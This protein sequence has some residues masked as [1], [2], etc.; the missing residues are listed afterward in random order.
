MSHDIG[1]PR[2][3]GSRVLPPD[4]PAS[5]SAG[6]PTTGAPAGPETG[7]PRF[8]LGTASALV[9][10]S[11][12]G[13]GVFALP[14]AL[15]V[16]GPISLVAFVLVTIGAIALAL[17]FR[18]LAVRLPGA[19]GPYVYARDAFGEFAGF[20][21]AWSYWI[22]AWA[23]NAAIVVAWVG[24]VEVFWNTGHE[25]GWSIVIALT[26]LLLPALVNLLGLRSFAAFQ[27]VTT[28]LKFIPLVFMATIGLLFINT[29][30]FGDFNASGTSW[31]GAISAAGAIALFSY[32][33]IETASVAA[34]RVRD[35]KRNVGRATVLGT[36]ACAAVYILGTVTVFGTVAHDDLVSSTA[37][38]TDAANVIFGG[39]WAGATVAAAAVVSGFGALVGWTLIVAEMPRAAAQDGLFPTAFARQNRAG[40]PAF[41]IVIS[42]LLAAG[43][44]VVSYTSFEQVFITVVLLSVLTSVVPY[45][46]SA[47]AQLYWLRTD[48]RR[49]RVRHLARDVVVSALALVFGFWALAGSGYAAVYYG[50]FCL[51]LGVPVYVWVKARR[52]TYGE[53]PAVTR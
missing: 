53:T 22:T 32:L 16:F 19:G 5:V 6:P 13:T 15:A 51:L 31:L 40:V 46:L 23:G 12:I 9:V 50:T 18:D 48:G 29:A 27:V 36:L 30:N 39:R 3:S 2:Q 38:F 21:I 24:Y 20:L 34:A 52:G 35:P 11:V 17:T 10:G 41:G 1:A 49:L 8:G 14:S 44:T 7:E 42:T 37:P 45:L 33:G 26:G 43:L 4:V 28:V 47:A 25:A